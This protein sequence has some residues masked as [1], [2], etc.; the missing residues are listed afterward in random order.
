MSL[1]QDFT[2]ANKNNSLI[3]TL[4]TTPAFGGAVAC[5]NDRPI[6]EIETTCLVFVLGLEDNIA[7]FCP[8]GIS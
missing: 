5:R 3:E 8:D 1:V 2:V 4:L 6:G 7:L